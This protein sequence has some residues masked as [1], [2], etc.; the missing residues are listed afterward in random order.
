MISIGQAA[1]ENEEFSFVSSIGLRTEKNCV[2]VDVTTDDEESI[3][4]ILAFDTIGGSATYYCIHSNAH[5]IFKGGNGNHAR[6]VGN[7]WSHKAEV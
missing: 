6:C 5:L 1:D 4:K 3:A 2:E 7:Y